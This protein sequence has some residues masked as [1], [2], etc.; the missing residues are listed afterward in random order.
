[1]ANVCNN[2]LKVYSDNEKNLDYV[3]KFFDNPNINSIREWVDNN[4]IEFYF[5]SKWIFPE[6]LMNKLYEG[7]SDK[8]DIDMTCLSVEQINLYCEFH[9]CDEEGWHS[10]R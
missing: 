2:T 1:M 9:T 8:S 4:E 10:I 6:E 7:L 5:D 3:C